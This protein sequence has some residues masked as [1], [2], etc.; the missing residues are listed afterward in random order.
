MKSVML[1][2]LALTLLLPL[3][4]CGPAEHT[5]SQPANAATTAQA[6][7]DAANKAPTWACARPPPRC[8]VC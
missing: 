5:D 4:A 8:A 2:T 1:N 7:P 3:A 6:A